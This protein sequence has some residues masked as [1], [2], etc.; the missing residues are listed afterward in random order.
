M[1]SQVLDTALLV[2]TCEMKRCLFSTSDHEYASNVP[3]VT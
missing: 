1:S 2:I 3:F